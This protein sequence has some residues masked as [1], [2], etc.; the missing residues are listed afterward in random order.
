MSGERARE[1]SAGGGDAA[2]G[3][4]RSRFQAFSDAVFA[5]SATLLVVT[6]EVPAS[7][8]ALLDA[9][10]GFPAFFLGFAALVSLWFNHREFFARYPLAD[11]WTV[12]INALL[13]FVVLLYVY[14]L[15]LLTEVVAERFLGAEADVT[16]G[17]GHDE[18]QGLFLIYGAGFV[19]V[20]ALYTVLHGRAWRLRDQLRLD[21][22]RRTELRRDA[23]TFAVIALIGAL[24]MLVA[25]LGLGLGWHLPFWVY[26]LAPAAVLGERIARTRGRPGPT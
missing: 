11:G 18:V 17:M 1:P 12:A 7:Y 25:A 22:P 2:V 8:E 24:S 6:L 23:A 16:I 21:G 19:A 26:V 9:L 4:E 20:F 10:S 3:R 15:K 14:S 5:L 13:L